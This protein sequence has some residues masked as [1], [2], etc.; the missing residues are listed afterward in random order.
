MERA[1]E[2][3]VH[4]ADGPPLVF[5]AIKETLRETM[6]LP[7]HEAFKVVTGRKLMSVDRLYGSEDQREGAVAFAEKRKPVWKGR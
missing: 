6:H 7:V 3:A 2:L 4:L 1:R 5:A